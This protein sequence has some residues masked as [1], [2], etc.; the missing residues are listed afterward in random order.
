MQTKQTIMDKEPVTPQSM[1][2]HF[3]ANFYQ[4]FQG[5]QPAG[6]FTHLR[7]DAVEGAWFRGR[8]QGLQEGYNKAVYDMDLAQH[9]GSA[10]LAKV[11]N[12]F[13]PARE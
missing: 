2:E 9:Q 4:A 1:L 13:P 8:A 12:G 3:V 11:Q 7:N 10:F 6:H 5:E